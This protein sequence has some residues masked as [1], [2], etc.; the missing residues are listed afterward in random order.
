MADPVLEVIDLALW[1]GERRLFEGL[2]FSLQSGQ[3]AI[4][5]GPNGAGKT[6]LLRAL[7]GLHMPASGRAISFGAPAADLNEVQRGNV[8]FQ[9]HLDGL[10]LDLTVRENL[11]FW[12]TMDGG[13]ESIETMIEQVGLSGCG[14]RLVR[15][16]SAGQRRRAALARMKMHRGRLC[17]LDEPLTNLDSGGRL[18]VQD[19][20]EEKLAAG[21]AVVVATHTPIQA[22]GRGRVEI[23]L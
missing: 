3:L 12:Q 2:G 22:A 9:G 21:C 19:W 16:L 13:Q 8:L 18:L 17:L 4:V 5:T 15:H 14:H 20:I 1:R 7:A 10:K 6:T 11:R 23:E